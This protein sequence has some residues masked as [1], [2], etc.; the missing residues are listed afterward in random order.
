[1][2]DD[3]AP[4]PAMLQLT[5]LN[6]D[7][8]DD[9]HAILARLR[10]RHPVFRDDMA[11]S[12]VVSRFKLARE[13]LNDRSMLRGPDKADPPGAFT[14]RLVENMDTD[15]E[16]GERRFY[17]ILLMDEPHHSRVRKPLAQ[18]LY[19]RS[20][21]CKPQVDEI[22]DAKLDAVEKH[23]RFDVLSEFAIPLPI[24][25]IG[26]ILGVDV[27]RRGEFR[28]W[29]EGVIQVLNP[30]RNAEQSAHL[31][32]AGEAIGAYIRELM[33]ARRA[34]P[35]DDL[36]TDMVR[37]KADGAELQDAEIVS[38]LIGLLVGGNLTTSD[39][40]GNGVYALLT[41]PGELAKLKAD[42]GIVNQVVEEILRYDGP[43]DITAR[44][45][46]HDMDVG[47]CPVKSHAS[48][49]TLLR[50]ANHDPDVFENP[51][52]FD[53]SR[54]PG[55]HIAFGGGSHICIGAPLARI[56]AQAA[57]SKLFQRF[58]KLRLADP[59]RRPDK[60]TLPFFNGIQRLDVL[61]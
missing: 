23:G 10:E 58:P 4:P 24:D 51:D 41:H 60:R 16:T 42:F 48:M 40:I 19:A 49:I 45:A 1:M 12:Y 59:G 35:Q 36:V 11:G 5:P 33:E 25:V 55:P 61:I 9:P 2:A 20:A 3:D 47:G 38:N 8:R 37:L 6:P 29:S 43:V 21:K 57:L 44:V 14:Q 18:A 30:F 22:I 32:R 28:D 17:S 53:V 7:Y 46:P 52:A 15:V 50:A 26:A 54:K 56:E 39:L 27:A 31:E 13:V 34:E